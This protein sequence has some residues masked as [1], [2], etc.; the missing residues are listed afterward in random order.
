[1]LVRDGSPGVVNL[2][3][4]L[5][6]R[7]ARDGLAHQRHRALI[8]WIHAGQKVERRGL[9]GA[10]GTDQRVEGAVGNGDIDALYC[11]DAAET[12]DHVAG[13]K[14]RPIDV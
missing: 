5:L 3:R 1:M 8:R 12:L 13:G 9:A 6:R 2:L 4:D 11:L 10:V 7:F 14:H